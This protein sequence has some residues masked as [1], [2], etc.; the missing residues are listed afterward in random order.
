VTVDALALTRELIRCNSVTPA[1]GGAQDVLARVLAGQGF[2]V[3]RL[4][5]GE[6]P[7]GPVDNLFA[8]IG[9]GTPHFAFAGHT[10]VVPPG[11]AADWSSDPFGGE[12]VDGR[13]VGRGAADMKSAIAAFVAA[14]RAPASGRLSLIITGDEEG[15]A[16]Y[17]TAPML[18]WMAANNLV[19]DLCLVGEP[20]SGT[21]LGDTVKIGR[22]G[23]LNAW[24]TV[25]GTQGHVAYPDRADN[26]I[27]R[28]V[29]ALA[30]LEA[31]LLDEGSDWF[32]P[33]NLEVTD[34]AVGNP[35]S[36]VI[37]A[38]ARARVNI[39]FNDHHEGAV[40]ERWL[41]DTV[42]E[43]APRAEIVVRISGEAFLTEPGDLSA[44]VGDAIEAVTGQ[45][46]ALST[47]GGTS[48]A[49]FI[50]SLCPVIEFGMVGATMHKIDE[51][52]AV[53]DIGALQAIY[54]GVLERVFGRV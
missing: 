37:P 53:T 22:R 31:R 5:F 51:S 18:A 40:L 4:R 34:L 28:L 46:P 3:H 48:D 17:G 6:A 47:S 45:P 44:I 36:N 52:V 16:T 10:D 39:R 13:L 54:A 50:R 20:T 25:P 9:E 29:A 21:V 7:D 33:S 32:Q 19:P 43:H 8:T 14:A 49:R 35:A 15:P 30:A 12:I 11:D 24:I 27:R 41:R 26:P 23:S 1:D 38:E 2:T 42:A